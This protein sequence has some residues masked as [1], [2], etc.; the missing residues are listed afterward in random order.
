MKKLTLILRFLHVRHPVRDFGC[1]RL[2]T[3]GNTAVPGPACA[4]VEAEEPSLTAWAAAEEA[5]SPGE[6]PAPPGA[7][8]VALVP[9]VRGVPETETPDGFDRAVSAG[10]PVDMGGERF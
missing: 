5:A 9:G 2:D 10:D 8:V 3:A 7:G 6:V 4:G 1:D